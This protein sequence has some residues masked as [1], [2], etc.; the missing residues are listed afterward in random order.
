MLST[1]P[2]L[3]ATVPAFWQL[4]EIIWEDKYAIGASLVGIPGIAMGRSRNMTWGLTASINDNSDLWE[5]QLNQEETQYFVDGKWRDL[6]IIEETIKVK[7][8]EDVKL[9][10]MHTH[11]G[12]IM[13]IPELR[14][15]AALLFGGTI[16]ELPQSQARYS[17]G[18]GGSQTED[19]S[20]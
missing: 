11:R 15:N 1:D 18:W 17:F 14:F 10:I 20:M 12:P 19:D 7:G 2:H 8:Q 4:N 16:P 3:A 6:K 5:E 9:R 13:Q